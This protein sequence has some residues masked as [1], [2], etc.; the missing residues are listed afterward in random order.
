LNSDI[1]NKVKDYFTFSKSQKGGIV[2]LSVLLVLIIAFNFMMPYIFQN[3]VVLDES[4]LQEIESF[5]ASVVEEKK[6]TITDPFPFDP[7][8]ISFDK[9][10]ELGLTEYQARMILKYRN[11]GG[12]FY[13]KEDFKRIY[14]IDDEDY[15]LLEPFIN[16]VEPKKLPKV[17]EFERE[18]NPMPF[19]PNTV[20]TGKLTKIGLS[21]N[22]VSQII[23]YRNAGGIFRIKSDF[24]K[25]YSISE[26]EYD[27][28]EK[29]ILL[30]SKI[31]SAQVVESYD[32]EKKSD[33]K[34]RPEVEIN[35]AD[36]NELTKLYGIGPYYAKKIVAYREKLGGFY[37]KAQLLEVFGI[38]ST[39]Y[40]GFTE[41]VKVDKEIIAKIDLNNADFREMLKHPY[42]EYYMV[43]EIFNYKDAVG[44]FRSV[45]ELKQI[46]LVYD[47]LYNKLEPYLTVE[48]VAI[49]K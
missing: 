6:T 49:E 45:S 34:V 1:I 19:N 13:K 24:K 39:R 33:L 28:L 27:Q 25:I 21:D 17:I 8:L 26:A 4:F 11:A 38:D 7:N 36:T 9:M 42:F 29:Y 41:Q 3:E 47:Q 31:D 46:D 2:I 20:D 18:I 35:S 37:D 14:S 16:I 43:K 23:N 5:R 32:E 30:P 10:I 44:D 22:Q 48:N 40:F 12:Q 15:N